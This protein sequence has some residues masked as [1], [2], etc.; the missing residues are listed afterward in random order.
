MS[1]VL[2]IPCHHAAFN[3]WYLLARIK[4][5]GGKHNVYIFDSM[6]IVFTKKNMKKVKELLMAINLIDETDNCIPMNVKRQTEQECG[7]RMMNYMVMFKEWVNRNNEA[8]SIIRQLNRA[9]KAERKGESDLAKASRKKISDF[10]KG[11]K[12]NALE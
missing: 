12:E 6:G 5:Q 2:L 10:L 8:R 1:T 11:Q 9:T 4:V 7:V 3:H